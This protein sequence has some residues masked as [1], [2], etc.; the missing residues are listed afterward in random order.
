MKRKMLFVGTVVDETIDRYVVLFKEEDGYHYVP[1]SAVSKQSK[2][3]RR[4]G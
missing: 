1:K 4:K 2:A 3:R